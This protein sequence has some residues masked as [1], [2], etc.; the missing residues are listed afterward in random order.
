MI[1]LQISALLALIMWRLVLCLTQ[2]G[3]E[4]RIL[5]RFSAFEALAR[6]LEHSISVCLLSRICLTNAP[7]SSVVIISSSVLC[8][9]TYRRYRQR[10][11]SV[12][13]TATRFPV[14]VPID[15]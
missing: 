6:D 13:A 9:T 4:V 5:K 11:R 15:P 14:V 1:R 8:S 10:P 7:L 2:Q 12:R 3:N